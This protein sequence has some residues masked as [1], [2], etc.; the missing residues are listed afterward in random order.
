MKSPNFT[1]ITAVLVIVSIIAGCATPNGSGSVAQGEPCQPNTAQSSFSP[2]TTSFIQQAILSP[3]AN[4]GG[5]LLATAA[6]NYSGKYSGKLNK[7]LT[8]LV[9]PKKKKKK[10][11]EPHP[12]DQGYPYDNQGYEP[13][14]GYENQID[15]NTGYP[16]ADPSG[17]PGQDNY[18]QPQEQIDPNTGFPLNPGIVDQGQ[19]DQG[20]PQEGFP[21]DPE[22]FDQEQV[23]QGADTGEPYYENVPPQGTDP[24]Y[25]GDYPQEV[26]QDG[27]QPRGVPGQL[28]HA[29]FPSEP[30]NPQQQV[31]GYPPAN[32]PY[33]NNPAYQSGGYDPYAQQQGQDPYGQSDPYA[34][35][36]YSQD[37]YG[38]Q[39]AQQDPYAQQQGQDP[40]GQSDPYAQH[41]YSQDPY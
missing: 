9:T 6:A 14:Y 2:T 21:I 19:F 36:G 27:V 34:Q 25:P 16:V 37:P 38:Q 7:L 40:Y 23:P 11:P 12:V 10:E 33:G 31:Q 32:Q 4:I 1:S 13:G 24:N 26:Y 3:L 35:H 22:T 39:P 30:C 8:K 29:T 15:P 5:T 20:L 28:S 18:G 41:G 17:Y